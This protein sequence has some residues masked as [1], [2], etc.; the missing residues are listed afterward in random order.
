M[1]GKAMNAIEDA[2]GGN[3]AGYAM[4]TL[5]EVMKQN[6]YSYQA[7][8]WA[9]RKRR[10]DMGGLADISNMNASVSGADQ[11]KHSGLELTVESLAGLQGLGDITPRNLLEDSWG[12][13]DALAKNIAASRAGGV[14][15]D[16]IVESGSAAYHQ[17]GPRPF[18]KDAERQVVE[19]GAVTWYL[20]EALIGA[21]FEVEVL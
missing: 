17:P 3:I 6:V 11:K 4:Q 1:M 20:T 19:S 14:R 16:R 12:G 8:P 10:G 7:S 9:M 15:L 18:Y 13:N 5:Q 21:G 2:L